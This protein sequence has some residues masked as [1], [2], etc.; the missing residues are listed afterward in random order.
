MNPN[1]IE[2]LNENYYRAYPLTSDSNATIGNLDFKTIIL[3]ANFAYQTNIPST[4]CLTSVTRSGDTITFTVSGLPV[5]T[6]SSA[7]T[8]TYPYYCFNANQDLL[9]ISSD[10]LNI[11][12]TYNV[13]ITGVQF[14]PSIAV[15]LSREYTGVTAINLNN[16][17]I[18]SGTVI[19][20]QG[21]QTSINLNGQ[22]IDVEVGQNYGIP[23]P[24]TNFFSS[25][26]PADCSSI[27]SSLNGVA[28]NT[29]GQMINI[30]AGQNV[31]IYTDPDLNRIY[32]GLDFTTAENCVTPELPPQP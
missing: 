7:S 6:I 2:W 3:D 1:S 15:D 11:P 31:K 30:V 16:S 29:T 13:T 12:S 20:Q 14:E 24:C 10:V 9:T 32:I 22:S 4:I 23:L 5:F 19:L 21:Y 27:I 8:Q 18:S 28:P 25:E 17:T 26:V